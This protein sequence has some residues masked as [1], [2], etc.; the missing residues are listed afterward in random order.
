MEAKPL[1][2]LVDGAL[3]FKRGVVGTLDGVGALLPAG[4]EPMAEEVLRASRCGEPASLRKSNLSIVEIVCCMISYTF[5]AIVGPA[6]LV[7]L[8]SPM[9]LV[10][11]RQLQ[12][13]LCQLLV[14]SPLSV[15]A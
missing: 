1:E 5:P 9:I 13:Q 14:A 2:C 8:V 3:V 12:L 7:G 10:R 6:G 11:L 15:E 4:A